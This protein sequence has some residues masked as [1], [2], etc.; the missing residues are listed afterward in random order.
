MNALT[1]IKEAEKN[2]HEYFQELEE[3]AYQ[4]GIKVLKAFQNHRV[5]DTH[6]NSTTGYGYGDMGRDTLE[7]IYAEVFESEDSLVRSR[8]ISGTHAISACLFGLLN[9]GD[10]LVSITGSPY[11]TL[12]NIIG[13]GDGAVGGTLI[14][15]GILYEEVALDAQGHPERENIKA[16]LSKKVKMVLIQRSRGYSLRP[17]LS[18]EE[19]KDLVQ[20]VKKHSPS[21]IVMVDNC[22]G[23]FTGLLEPT[24]VGADIMAGSLIKNPGGGVAGGGGYICG[25]TPLVEQVADYLVAPGLGKELG[26]SLGQNRPMYQGF[27][28][29]PHTVL[30]ALK[31]AVLAAYVFGQ[32]G[33]E[34]Y[35]RWSEP[36]NDIVQT[37][38]LGSGQQIKDYCQLVQ[39]NSPVDSDVYLEFAD[40]PG[41]ADK[42]IM[43]AGTFVQGSSIELSCDGPLRPPYCVYMQG[44]LTYEHGRYV[45]AQLVEQ[46][47][48]KNNE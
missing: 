35:P 46:I 27:F 14:K 1:V 15:R 36:R 21:T 13:C 10:R 5:R 43:A 22:Y 18:P 11:D 44:G 16:I 25:K 2:L 7:Q 33:Y 30:Q 4:N 39:K 26:P 24:G 9:P 19:I 48:L 45:L 47:I 20:L 6:F 32:H 8:I 17:A 29:A 42:I 31:V 23:E 38:V 34:V 40:M 28:L 37:I 41:Y 12:S 3:I